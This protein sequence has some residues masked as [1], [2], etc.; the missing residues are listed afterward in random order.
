MISCRLK[1]CSIRFR[2]GHGIG[3]VEK[4]FLQKRA[5]EPFQDR[6]LCREYDDVVDHGRL[7]QGGPAD[8]ARQPGQGPAFAPSG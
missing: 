4:S 5:N 6:D 8:E 2:C 3:R 1:P 7:L